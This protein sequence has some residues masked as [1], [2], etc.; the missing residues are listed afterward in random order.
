MK[1]MFFGSL[2]SLIGLIGCGTAPE[3]ALKSESAPKN[4]QGVDEQGDACQLR[5]EQDEQ[6]RVLGV[7]L[8]GTYIADYKVPMPFSGL[9]GKYRWPGKFD[10]Q[11]TARS[12]FQVKRS[13]WGDADVIKGEG[14]PLFWNTGTHMH[15]LTAKPSLDAAKSISYLAKEKLAGVVTTVEIRMDCRFE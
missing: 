7:Q 8:E 12:S 14:E 10:S 11:K 3:S 9:Y 2:L 6:G 1:S 4:Y 5:V 13:I 15:T